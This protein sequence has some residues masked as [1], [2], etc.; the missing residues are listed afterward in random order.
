MEPFDSVLK[1]KKDI[2]N[3]NKKKSLMA[4]GLPD[5]QRASTYQLPLDADL[6]AHG[7]PLA[8]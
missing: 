4:F 8:L 7:F 5:L 2:K 6:V 3:K 1:K